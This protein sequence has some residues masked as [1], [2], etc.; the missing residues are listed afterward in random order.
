MLAE[1]GATLGRMTVQLGLSPGQQGLLVSARFVGG[2]VLG[3]VLWAGSA[4]L[5]LRSIYGLSVAAVLLSGALLLVPGYQ[6]ALL[7]A[8]I[9]GLSVGALIPL[10]GV[11]AA[12]Q[13]ERDAGPVTAIVN[14]ALS[15]GL[16]TLSIVALALSGAAALPW[17]FYWVLPTLVSLAL[18]ILF[19]RVTFPSV[20]EE[21]A[22]TS[23]STDRPGAPAGLLART[24]WTIAISA[25]FTVSAESVL[26]GLVPVRT[27]EI[28][29]MALSVEV[30]ALVLVTGVMIGRFLGRRW[31][32][33]LGPAR[34]F[35]RAIVSL[36]AAGALW[37]ALLV[38]DGVL[39]AGVAS[40]FSAVVVFALGLST[41]TI[42]PALVSYSALSDRTVATTTISAIGWTAGIGGTGMPAAAGAALG[43]GLSNTFSMIFVAG[44]ALVAL[45]L[46]LV[47]NQRR[48]PG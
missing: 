28:G 18:L 22:A 33:R 5:K 2:V 19:P 21:L 6:S 10:S 3:L 12:N 4:R 16:V 29:G 37:T 43:V 15:A 44:P 41:A 1:T 7:I 40:L 8:T 14:A 13:H 39:P 35:V 25:A 36:C 45:L 34:L 38:A 27:A 24:D 42:F 31:I 9:R 20:G 46:I 47:H 32:Q 23:G 48:I 11:Y 30:I 26:I 17:Q